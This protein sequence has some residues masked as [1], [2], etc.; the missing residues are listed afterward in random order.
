MPDAIVVGGGHNGLVCACY[1]ARVGLDVLVLEGADYYGGAVHTRESFPGFR[2]DTCSVAHN[3]INMTDI[4][5]EL[6]LRDCGLEYREM[7]PFTTSMRPDGRILRFYRSV[8]RTCEEIARVAPEDAEG[9]RRFIARADPLV[10]AGLVAFSGGYPRRL[11][12][13]AMAAFRRG[14]YTT[15]VDVLAPYGRLLAATFQS[16]AVRAPLAALAAHAT[17]G[18]DSPG[19]SLFVLWQAAYHRYGMWHARGGSGMLAKALARR[20]RSLGGRIRTGAA[21]QWILVNDGQ[22]RGVELTDGERIESKRIAAA[23]H[24]KTALLRLIGREYLSPA[25]TQRLE[26]VR[27]SNAVQYVIHVPLEALPVYRGLD[28]LPGDPRDVFNG[29]QTVAATVEHVASGFRAAALGLAP[30]EPAV[31]AFT[32]SAL[33]TT[34]APPDR[35]TLY[36]ACPSYPA[37][38][39]EGSWSERGRPEAERLLA[40]LAAAA[41][42]LRASGDSLSLWTPDDM[43]REI[44]LEGAHPMH[45]DLSIDQLGPLRPLPELADHRTPIRGLYL[46]AAGSSPTGGVSGVPGRAAARAIV[47]DTERGRGRRWWLAGA[48]ASAGAAG[49]LWSRRTGRR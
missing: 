43:E 14:L 19:G 45:V 16:E 9:Y 17:V 35:H 28:A 1:L 13:G 42:G 29:M 20:L 32:P 39:A 26:A 15:G 12:A 2:F 24:P 40:A 30:A 37:R 22:V 25:L 36:L 33:D 49:W 44:G 8:E 48:A 18:P 7:D 34:L 46:A 4:L 10:E 21:V 6:E 5:E 3:M 47:A 11:S 31:Y 27:T 23:I 41:P 38:L